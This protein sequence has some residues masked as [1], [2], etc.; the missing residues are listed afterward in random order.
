ML[1]EELPL[2]LDHDALEAKIHILG[3]RVIEGIYSNIYIY[4]YIYAY[5]AVYIVIYCILGVWTCSWGGWTSILS[6]WICI[7]GVAPPCVRERSCVFVNALCVRERSCVFV[8][9][10]CS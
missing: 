9:A 8:N 6:V 4:I 2:L 1:L 5:I 3:S 10:L 7:F